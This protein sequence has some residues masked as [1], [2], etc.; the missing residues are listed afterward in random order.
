MLLQEPATR[1]L[2]DFITLA[3]TVERT[4][5]EAPAL[6]SS[7]QLPPAAIDQVN[8]RYRCTSLSSESAMAAG[9]V[10][11]IV[12]RCVQMTALPCPWSV[13]SKL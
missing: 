4:M 6:S 12:I 13:L 11:S 5:S 1:T 3:L 2:E 8:R 9:T 10:V 7:A